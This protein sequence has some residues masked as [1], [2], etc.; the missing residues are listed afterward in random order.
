MNHILTSTI[1]NIKSGATMI[2]IIITICLSVF[3]LSVSANEVKL[4]GI[5]WPP[6]TY[7]DNGKI[8]K[9]ISHDIHEEAFKRLDLKFERSV[10]SWSRCVAQVENGV[11]DAVI[12]NAPVAPFIYGKVPTGVYPLGVY[13][14]GDSTESKFTWDK[15]KDKKVGMV[16]GYDYTESIINFKD[17]KVKHA[18]SDHQMLLKLKAKRTDYAILDIFSASII[19]KKAD[20]NIKMLTPLVDSTN[21]YLVFNKDKQALASLYDNAIQSMVDDGTMNKIYKTYLEYDYSQILDMQGK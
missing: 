5:E 19:A 18:K 9:G 6:F 4:C 1:N 20:V 12:D 13:V 11:Y 7:V 8:V 14:L 21:L 15:M 10:M 17:W 2:K 16:R 3:S